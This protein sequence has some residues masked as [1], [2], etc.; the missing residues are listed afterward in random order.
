MPRKGRQPLKLVRLPIPPPGRGWAGHHIGGRTGINLALPGR[1]ETGLGARR[2]RPWAKKSAA[3]GAFFSG[4]DAMR[5]RPIA[6]GLLRCAHQVCAAAA[7]VHGACVP[8]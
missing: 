4:S 5:Q 2:W 6:T 3:R 8:L 1:Q 7:A